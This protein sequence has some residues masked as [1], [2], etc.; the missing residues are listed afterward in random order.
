MAMES[1]SPFETNCT[2]LGKAGKCIYCKKS[3]VA[4]SEEHIIPYG[5]NGN[6]VLLDASC[7]DCSKIT[8]AFEGDVL[9]RAFLLPRLGFKMRTRH[10]KNKDKGIK[11]SLEQNSNTSFIEIP[12]EDCP[13]LFMMPIF[14]PPEIL[15]NRPRQPG[16]QNTGSF[17]SN[18]IRG[19]PKEKLREKYGPGKIGINISYN[20][21]SFARMLAKIAYGFAVAH[22]G[23][24]DIE[25]LGIVSSIKGETD[26]ISKWVGCVNDE[27]FTPNNVLHSWQLKIESSYQIDEPKENVKG[28]LLYKICLFSLFGTPEYTIFV[29]NIRNLADKIS[30][31]V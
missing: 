20:P 25:D 7:G 9:G 14:M 4:L 17:Y 21:N 12:A 19:I 22:F 10:G 5:L 1:P 8:S 13:I 11:V 6:Q 31:P 2:V 24:D 28:R 26:D 30:L 3:D 16:I 15:D 23:V 27:K 29:G 18:E